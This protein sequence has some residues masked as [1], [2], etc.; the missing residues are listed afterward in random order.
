MV[1][2]KEWW[3]QGV[4]IGVVEVKGWVVGSMGGRGLGW[5]SRGGDGEAISCFLVN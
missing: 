1:G 2:S 3:G 5:G 4:G